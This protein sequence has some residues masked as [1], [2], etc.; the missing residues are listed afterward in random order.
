M[1]KNR[2]MV[3]HVCLLGDDPT[4]NITP[5]IDKNIQSDRLI[6]AH[7]TYQEKEVKALTLIAQ[8]R[9]CKVD[10]WVLPTTFLTEEIKL[11]FLELFEKESKSTQEI[12]LNA[13]NGSKHQLLSA[14]EMARENNYPI[15][16]V[17]P[18][19]DAL[20]WLYPEKRPLTPVTDQVKLHEFF[21][22]NGCSLVSQKNKEGISAT[23]RELGTS[24]LS[25]ADKLQKDSYLSGN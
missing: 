9:G 16:I 18:K 4:A 22:L 19:Y 6:I 1:E 2:T 12:W 23:F 20:C 21:E 5:I 8:T 10:N 14:Y 11:S 17:E 7:E 24:W 25:K 3:T 15:F 13:S